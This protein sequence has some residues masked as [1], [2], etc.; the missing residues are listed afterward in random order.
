MNPNKYYHESDEEYERR[1]T[2][3]ILRKK[4][5][6]L[7]KKEVEEF[8]KEIN[9]IYSGGLFSNIIAK[10]AIGTLI[11]LAIYYY[12]D[13]PLTDSLTIG[14]G[15]AFLWKYLLKIMKRINF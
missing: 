5:Q 1:L 12:Q 2:R 9:T 7:R 8:D 13:K 4:A 3:E 6:E 10:V 14:I 11:G 15:L